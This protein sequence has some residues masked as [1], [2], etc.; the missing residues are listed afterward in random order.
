[1]PVRGNFG[2]CWIYADGKLKEA[3]ELFSIFVSPVSG[4]EF[5]VT[6]YLDSGCNNKIGTVGPVTS[7]GLCV[8]SGIQPNGFLSYTFDRPVLALPAI[9]N[10]TQRASDRFAVRRRWDA[11]TPQIGRFIGVLR[12]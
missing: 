8:F 3:I 10:L 2:D 12:N 5:T 1:V 6:L 11:V 7:E 4:G 9:H